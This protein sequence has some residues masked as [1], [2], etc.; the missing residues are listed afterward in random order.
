[1][2]KHIPQE[3]QFC[4]LTPKPM[5]YI[6]QVYPPAFLFPL[7][8]EDVAVLNSLSKS[9]YSRQLVK[10][11]QYCFK[12]LNRGTAGTWQSAP[13]KQ[14]NKSRENKWKRKSVY[15]PTFDSCE[16]I[17]SFPSVLQ[18]RVSWHSSDLLNTIVM[19]KEPFLIYRKHQQRKKI[20]P[21]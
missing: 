6:S 11:Q 5:C 19:Q 13:G 18:W 20:K 4:H 7:E 14:C 1:M 9:E 10:V 8:H 3:L 12:A 16:W 17:C 21:K 15:I 2:T